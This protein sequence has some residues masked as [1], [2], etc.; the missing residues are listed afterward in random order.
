MTKTVAFMLADGCEP[1]EVVAPID[2]LRRG[3]VDVTLVATMGS[4]KITTAQDLSLNAD[5]LVEE[6]S[7]DDFDVIVL[8]GGGL[9]VENLGKCTVLIEELKARLGTPSND[10]SKLVAAICAAP[11]ILADN[12]LLDGRKATCYP[13]CQT[14]FPDGVYQPNIA[15]CIDG[16]L[17][18]SAGPGTALQFGHAILCVLMGK[19]VADEVVQGMLFS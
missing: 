17:I 8:P 10:V 4:F 11:M 16:N 5:V 19:E 18:T 1:V 13:G 14:N 2:V 6:V 15:A 9:G 12:N 7:L 3:G